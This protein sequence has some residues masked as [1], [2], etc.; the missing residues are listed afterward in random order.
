LHASVRIIHQWHDWQLDPEL[1][2]RKG[3]PFGSIG[4]DDSQ[5][6]GLKCSAHGD[7]PPGRLIVP[8]KV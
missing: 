8:P 6:D 4:I 5:L 2:D 3:C 1:R 7:E